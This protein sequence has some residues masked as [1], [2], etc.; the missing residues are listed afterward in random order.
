MSP[1]DVHA[2]I[3]CLHGVTTHSGRFAPMAEVMTAQGIAVSA[4]DLRGHGLNARD[5]KCVSFAPENC[6][7]GGS[8]GWKEQIQEFDQFLD[9][10]QERFPNA[11][12]FLLGFSL[13]SFLI[14]DYLMTYPDRH[15]VGTILL[16]TGD[17]PAIV[18]KVMKA[19]LR[20]QMR[21][22]HPGECSQLVRQ[23]SFGSYNNKFKPNTTHADW[24]TSD[25][26]Q[27]ESYIQDPLCRQEI[28]VDL[29]Y[30]MLDA[31]ERTGNLKNV[32]RTSPS[33][34]VPILILAGDQD[35]VGN[36]GAGIKSFAKKLRTAGSEDVTVCMYHNARHDLLHETPD[37][38][39]QVIAQMQQWVCAHC[40]S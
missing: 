19:I 17:Q 8:Y 39:S 4:L 11:R 24:L 33:R 38:V 30:E 29:L 36:M 5:P 13:G 22:L 7:V 1:P 14:R 20:L 6:P 34:Q 35:P 10:M 37:I 18:M 26:A 21:K 31:I 12:L 15:H 3:V 28:S 23:L 2:L 32:S 16:G 27:I 40:E 9:I 25:V